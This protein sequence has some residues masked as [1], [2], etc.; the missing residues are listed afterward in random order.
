METYLV[1]GAVRDELLGLDV[2]ERDYVVVGASESELVKAG[3]RS[4]GKDFPVYLHPKT[5]DEY[6]LARTERRIGRGHRAFECNTESVT[7]EEDLQRRDLTI[8]AIARDD[9]G[10]LIDPVGGLRDLEQK[11]LRHVSPAFSED[12]LRILRV[13]R[14]AARFHH[15]GFMIA[16]ET[17]ALMEQMVADGELDDLTPERVLLELDKAMTTS[18]PRVFFDV[19][20][21][22]GGHARLWP[23]LNASGLSMLEQVTGKTRD[24]GFRLVAAFTGTAADEAEKILGHYRAP[25]RTLFL[26]KQTRRL[27]S[28]FGR[29]EEMSATEIVD[30]L[31][32]MDA[33]RQPER[34]FDALELASYLSAAESS[35]AGSRAWWQEAHAALAGIDRSDVDPALKG[36]L[37]G[38]AIRDARVKRIKTW[39]RDA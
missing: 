22:V 33:F 24:P 1:G 26:L 23:G 2:H 19:I 35:A 39:R 5:G 30:T 13:A 10:R 11:Q 4:V 38:D 17:L 31:Y 14:F 21:R 34:F 37:I 18:S 12:P 15:L 7:L 8:N 3:F 36:P 28:A 25:N 20:A 16:E 6:A 32:G 27:E 9:T 29:H